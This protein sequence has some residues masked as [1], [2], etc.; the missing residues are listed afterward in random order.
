VINLEF[1]PY[2]TFM[3]GDDEDEGGVPLSPTPIVTRP[4]SIETSVSTTWSVSGEAEAGTPVIT[5]RRLQSVVGYNGSAMIAGFISGPDEVGKVSVYGTRS[6]TPGEVFLGY[7]T[8]QYSSYGPGPM[9][10]FRASGLNANTK[11]RVHIDA[12]DDGEWT[13][14]NASTWINVRA[15]VGL[16]ASDK[17]FTAGKRITLTSVVLPAGTAGGAV[18]FQQWNALQKRWRSIDS[19]KLV[20]MG[21][22]TKG[23]I[24]W[25]PSRG[26]HRIRA[27]YSGG[28]TN[29]A[30]NSGAFNIYV[31]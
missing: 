22:A 5:I 19:A 8:V 16:T 24:S 20:A 10:W 9:F 3:S 17:H 28:P 13:S 29:S 31:K 26:T 6:G 4:K 12:S 21:G 2:P 27:H 7:A 30:G 23:A 1:E 15:K 14:A 25:K 18:T 11:L